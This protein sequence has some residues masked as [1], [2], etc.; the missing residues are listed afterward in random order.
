[1]A[2]VGGERE[3]PP[4][5]NLLRSGKTGTQQMAGAGTLYP[6]QTVHLRAFVVTLVRPAWAT[7]RWWKTTTP[8]AVESVSRRQGCPSWGG[9]WRKSEAK[10]RSEEYELHTRLTKVGW[11]CNT[12]QSPTLPKTLGVNV[13][14]IWDEGCCS[15]LGRSDR[16]IANK[17][18]LLKQ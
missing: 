12:K 13:A 1:M 9:I 18:E 11:V 17:D 2:V 16:Y 15:Y 3:I 4:R 10:S 8:S 14:D 5:G 6:E 7:T